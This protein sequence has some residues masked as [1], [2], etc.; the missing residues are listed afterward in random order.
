MEEVAEGL[1]RAIGSIIRWFLLELVFQIVCFNL[2]RAFLLIVT[3][4]KYP[5]AKASE[6]NSEGIALVGFGVL[7]AAWT[8]IALY[9]NFT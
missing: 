6:R 2:G 1:F 3:L 7:A 8:A 5:G 4:G 9:N